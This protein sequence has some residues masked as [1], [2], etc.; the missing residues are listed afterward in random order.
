MSASAAYAGV[1]RSPVQ[2]LLAMAKPLRPTLALAVLSGALTVGCGI[3]LLGVSG[4]LIAR[5]SEHPNEVA[6]AVAVV[7]VR[8]FGIGRGAF[9]YVERLSSHDAA[10]RVMADLRVSVYRRLERLV[11]AGLVGVRNGD[12]LARVISDVDAVQDLFIRGITPPLVAGCVGAGTIVAA[13]AIFRPGAAAIGAGLLTAGVAVPWLAARLARRADAKRAAAQ[14]RL[15]VAM[16]DV[17][18]GAAELLAFGAATDALRELDARDGDITTI[19]RRSATVGAVSI[20]LTSAVTGGTVWA[21]LILAVSASHPG[22]LQRV[23][24][25]ADVLTGLAAFEAT[26][27]M[28]AAAQQLSSVRAS[29][30]RVFDVLDRP[31][32]VVVP[33]TP[34]TVPRRAAHLRV[35]GARLRY[36]ADAPW[37]LDGVSL[38]LPP[39]RRLAIVGHSGSGK[40]TLAAALVR[41]R[42]LDAG[43]ITL[44]GIPT[45]R[46]DDD[47]VRTVISGCLADPHVFDST[48]RENLRLASPA[49]SQADLD[50]VAER[51]RLLGWIHSLPA[52]W[53]TRVGTHG[54][55]ISGGQR[56]RLALARA[57]LADPQILILDEPTAHLDPETR[58]ALWQ[59][60]IAAT[61]GRSLILITH[62][63]DHLELLD[64][65]VVLDA[66][67]VV[68][69]G[70]A[71]ELRRVAGPFR[72]LHAAAD[73]GESSAS[74]RRYAG[75]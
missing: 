50:G 6:L 10:F 65:V 11:P 26:A 46:F 17:V 36:D 51:V 7:A 55:A 38:D 56:Q 49:A 35:V 74:S 68:Q 42:D 4:F 12:L 70:S 18:S 39:R 69:R 62:D 59:D 28:A 60:I 14:G 72:R 57:L 48:I 22:G 71:K 24:L 63:L 33:A 8:A 52:G 16:N 45:T 30:R 5:A 19:A 67:R 29:A 61:A 66:G 73:Q 1:G 21:L 37:A 43:E 75:V 23:G 13:L 40:S 44:N 32:P 9:R 25:A 64:E 15:A 47:D 3:A 31:D 58:D 2:R 41:F 53:D 34:L 27:P 54:G 20:G